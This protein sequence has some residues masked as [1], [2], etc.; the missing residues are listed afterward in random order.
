[1]LFKNFFELC[2]SSIIWWL[3]GYAFAWGRDRGVF[4]GVT[5]FATASFNFR[6]TD[7]ANFAYQWALAM[8]AGAIVLGPVSERI[9]LWSAV[10]FNAIFIGWIYPLVVHWIWPGWLY[11]MGLID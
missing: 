2:S 8:V 3:V 7:F 1:M 5:N 11:N 10:I 4:L 6:S 9:T